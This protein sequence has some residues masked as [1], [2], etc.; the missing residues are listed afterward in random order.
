MVE[1]SRRREANHDRPVPVGEAGP[2]LESV[3]DP[4]VVSGVQ[5]QGHPG[6]ERREGFRVPGKRFLSVQKLLAAGNRTAG[7]I[8]QP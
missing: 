5:V 2:R 4:P 6:P 3:P 7:A 8:A 1:A